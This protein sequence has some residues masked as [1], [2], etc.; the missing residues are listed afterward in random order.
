MAAISPAMSSRIPAGA[1]ATAEA[2]LGDVG[3]DLERG[4]DPHVGLDQELLEALEH[5]VVEHPALLLAQQPPD[6][7]GALAALGLLGAAGA[8]GSGAGAAR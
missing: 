6:E 4:L 1:D 7:A 3:G 2:A 5:G 8:K